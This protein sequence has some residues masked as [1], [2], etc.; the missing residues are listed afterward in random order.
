M[1]DSASVITD[2]L[3]FL[4][5][6]SVCMLGLDWEALK[7][8]WEKLC[9]FFKVWETVGSVALSHCCSGPDGGKGRK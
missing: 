3:N 9:C 5:T 6:D 8:V 1:S 7:L 4:G 2:H